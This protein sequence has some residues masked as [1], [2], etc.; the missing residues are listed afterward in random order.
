MREN[1]LSAIYGVQSI[2]HSFMASHKSVR[3]HDSLREKLPAAHFTYV[4]LFQKYI[5]I[6]IN[7]TEVFTAKILLYVCFCK[8]SIISYH[9]LNKNTS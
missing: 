4:R 6:N 5:L 8:T 2:Y 7:I 1:M 9:I 3:L